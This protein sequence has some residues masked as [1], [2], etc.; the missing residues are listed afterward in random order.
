MGPAQESHNPGLRLFVSVFDCW[1]SLIVSELI[2]Y[3]SWLT[4]QLWLT[5]IHLRPHMSLH[6]GMSF[7]CQNNLNNINIEIMKNIWSMVSGGQQRSF[8]KCSNVHVRISCRNRKIIEHRVYLVSASAASTFNWP[9][10]SS[11]SRGIQTKLKLEL[12]PEPNKLFK[13]LRIIFK[14]LLFL[15]SRRVL[16]INHAPSFAAIYP[17]PNLDWQEN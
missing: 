11:S 9:S 12:M 16:R 15:V 2:F 6:W 1:S 4:S 17:N 7:S 14:I 3:T 8:L 10:L 13:C 5:N